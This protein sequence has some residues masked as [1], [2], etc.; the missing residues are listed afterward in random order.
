MAPTLSL[1]PNRFM[2]TWNDCGEPSGFN[3]I[4]SPSSIRV[5]RGE[6]RTASTIS[7]TRAVTSLRVRV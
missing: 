5:L 4:A 7:G 1:R 2:V 6:A 3:A